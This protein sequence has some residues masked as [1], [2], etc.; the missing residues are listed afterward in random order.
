[1]NLLAI[2]S[3]LVF[4]IA[5]LALT[6]SLSCISESSSDTQQIETTRSGDLPNPPKVVDADPDLEIPKEVPEE[7]KIIWESWEYLSSDYV[8]KTKLDPDAFAEAAIWGMLAALGDPEMSY[9]SPAVM[10]GRFQDMFRG[11][12]EGIGAH[13]NMNRSGKLII[14]S[15][16]DGSPAKAAGI[17]AGDIVLEVDGESL[18]G[19]GLMEAVALIRGPKG[20]VVTLLVKHLGDLDPVEIEITRGVILLPSIYLRS[21][22]DDRYAHIR[23][24]DFYPNTVTQLKETL[25]EVIDDGAQGLILDLRNNP[26]GTLDSVVDV[27]S[28]F[29]DGGLVLYQMDGNGNRIDYSVRKGG[30]ALDIP[31]VVLVNEGSASSSEVLVGALQDRGRA[32]IIGSTTYGKGSVNHMRRLSNGGGLYITIGYWYTPLGRLIQEDGLKP[33]ILVESRAPQTADIEQL[34]RAKSELDL[35]TNYTE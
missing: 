10:T 1:M 29:L 22:P 27:A 17:R 2:R 33:D 24:T 34:K 13:V 31:T 32:T 11:D 16:I 8:D 4:L 3:S 6:F 20:S 7:L 12:F 15:P 19:I 14:V 18:E 23:V 30:I 28:Q 21:E 25:T 9:I 5:T 35:H 26:G